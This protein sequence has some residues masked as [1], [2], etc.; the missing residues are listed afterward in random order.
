MLKERSPG[1]VAVVGFLTF[2]IYL[3]YWFYD[4]N[5]QFREVTGEDSH[6]MLRTLALFV[7]FLN[8]L[9]VFKHCRS[10]EEATGG[11][12]WILPFLA[13]LVFFPAA[14]FLIQADINEAI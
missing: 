4:T 8:L 13:Y 10:S 12:E 2:G 6:P 3:L 7:P 9:A 5:V 1:F 11:H 14:M